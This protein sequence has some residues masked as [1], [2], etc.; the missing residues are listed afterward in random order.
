MA[1]QKEIRVKI[2]S[3][4]K[5]MKIT[6]AMKLVAAA[7]VNKMQKK[8]LATRPY[9][10]K[11][12][13]LFNNLVTSLNTEDL[14]NYPL[15]QPKAQINTVLLLVIS[16]DRGL[17]GAYNAN[18]IK[19][20]IKEIQALQDAGKKVQL[21][22]VGRKA[23]AA[24]SKAIYKAQSVE[25]IESFIN[26]NSMPTSQEASLITNKA[27]E[28]YLEGSVDKVK[29]ITTKFVSLVNSFVEIH[30]FLP[31][32]TSSESKLKTEPYVVYDPNVATLIETLAPMYI[33]NRVYQSMQESTTSELAAR[34]TAMSNAT[35]NARDVIKKLTLAYNKARQASITQE[36]SEIVGGAAALSS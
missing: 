36:I 10:A 8:L 6:S 29:I 12:A 23:K 30:D 14:E 2:G 17:C 4:K 15:L 35:N 11:I 32:Q 5:T 25:L 33:E 24:F 31:V 3:T 34:M 22:T 20:T 28:L 16:S 21:I 9:S 13:E 26:L 19:A 1:N 18:I 27:I 7:K